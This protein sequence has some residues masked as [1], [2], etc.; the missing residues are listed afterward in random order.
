MKT[1]QSGHSYQ[2]LVKGM[3]WRRGARYDSAWLYD[4]FHAI[5]MKS[6]VL[7]F[8][9]DTDISPVEIFRNILTPESR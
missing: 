4:Q 9:A 3:Q 5:G 6:F 1:R 7:G 2:E 8:T